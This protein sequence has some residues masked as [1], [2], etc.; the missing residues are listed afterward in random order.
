[1]HSQAKT[2]VDIVV[3][4]SAAVLTNHHRVAAQIDDEH[5]NRKNR[6]IPASAYNPPRAAA[7]AVT[8]RQK[9]KHLAVWDIH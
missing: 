7:S 4:I 9:R 1:V 2:L 8:A 5:K 3:L 6:T